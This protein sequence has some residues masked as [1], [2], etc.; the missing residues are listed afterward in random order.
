M[1]CM[2]RASSSRWRKVE[3]IDIDCRD[4]AGDGSRDGYACTCIVEIQ[5]R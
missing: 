1:P 3:I 2:G 5:L 4:P